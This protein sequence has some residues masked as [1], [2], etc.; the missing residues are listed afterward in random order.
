MK[1]GGQIEWRAVA[2]CEM[3]KTSCQTEKHRT[4]DDLKNHS[5]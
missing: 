1:D 4:K 5:K 3:F 2:I